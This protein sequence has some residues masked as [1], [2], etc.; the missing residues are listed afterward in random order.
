MLGRVFA[1]A[2]NT[3][4]EAARSKIL[5]AIA[6]LVV[7]VNFA[8]IGCGVMSYNEEARVAVDF[9]LG[10]VSIF[11]A[12]TAIVL[13][14]TLLYTEVQK[15]TIH[16]I[17][18]KPIARH[19]FVLGKYAGMAMTLTFLVLAFGA[20]LLAQLVFQRADVTAALGKAVLLSW[21]EVLIVAAVAIFF[22]SFST[23][24]LSGLLTLGLWI[25]G[26]SSDE[27]MRVAARHK[28]EAFRIIAEVALYIVPDLHIYSVSGSEV[29]GQW[30]S[31]H[32]TFVTWRYVGTAAA[33]AAAVVAILL[34]L[35]M[36]IFS[37]RDFT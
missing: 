7:F 4:R 19:E 30:V 33:Y 20:A 21:L 13:G 18:A 11:G 9:G 25:I 23:P 24:F 14:V 32:D 22:S 29:S 10:A 17:L 35:A 27:L 34:I 12:L 36:A 8:A 15:R 26:R 5:Y 28:V 37:R 16:V 31:V 2:L 1:I 3:F 6:L